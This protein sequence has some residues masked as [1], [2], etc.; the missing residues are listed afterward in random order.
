MITKISFDLITKG[1]K[2]RTTSFGLW[3]GMVL[4]KQKARAENLVCEEVNP[5][6]DNAVEVKEK[7]TKE[8]GR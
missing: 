6:A 8:N 3:L 2:I 5:V 7:E 1:G 4:A